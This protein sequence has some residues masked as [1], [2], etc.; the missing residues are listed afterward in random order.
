MTSPASLGQSGRE[1][2]CPPMVP[3][4]AGTRGWY[5]G[6]SWPSTT[7][8]QYH[9]RRHDRPA[10]VVHEPRSSDAGYRLTG[11]RRAVAALDR[12]PDG[13]L[14]GRRPRRRRQGP[15][16]S[17]SVG[18]RSS[19]RSTSWPSCGVVERID[20]PTGEHAYVACEPVHHHHVVC[21][22]CGP[23]ADVDD[24]GCG[25]CVRDVARRTG[26][27]VDDHRLEL[28]G[29]VP[30]LPARSGDRLMPLAALAVSLGGV[31]VGASPAAGSRCAR[32]A[33]SG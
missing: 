11:A 10:D 12:R 30:G 23:A 16:G 14:H 4:D 20:L 5:R 2:G 18:R 1:P 6:E 28:F 22:G 17:G 31:R 9:L 7:E 33:T 32:S 29:A 24:A 3:R 25:P 8:T 15:R 19:G 13:P 27:R 26:Y 21:S